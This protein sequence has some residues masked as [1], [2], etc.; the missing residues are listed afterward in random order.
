[1]TELRNR[2]ASYMVA[3]AVTVSV[4]GFLLWYYSLVPVILTYL[5]G[6]AVLI[7][8]VTANSV[9]RGSVFAMNFGVILSIAAVVSSASSYAHLQAMSEIFHGG[10]ISLL[11]VLEILGFYVFPLLYI[12]EKLLHS[13][14]NRNKNSSKRETED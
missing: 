1:M 8:M 4:G 14:R 2:M 9:R 7:V 6:T 11:D 13:M 5:T 12:S 10:I 3:S